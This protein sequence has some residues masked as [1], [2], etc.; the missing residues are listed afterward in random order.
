MSQRD[1]KIPWGLITP[2]TWQPT[3][4]RRGQKG[5]RMTYPQGIFCFFCLKTKPRQF[6]PNSTSSKNP[7]PNSS[8]SPKPKKKHL[9]FASLP[10]EL[11]HLAIASSWHCR[12]PHPSDSA[13]ATQWG[14]EKYVA[15][16]IFPNLAIGFLRYPVF[17]TQS[18]FFSWGSE[19]LIW[20][21]GRFLLASSPENCQAAAAAC[22]SQAKA[23]WPSASRLK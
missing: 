15:G 1:A 18:L 7:S 16:S 17:L 20:R 14:W 21:F 8:Q 23:L 2:Q 9:A 11:V 3:K 13:R 4:E 5:S 6:Y 22:A 12:P 10:A 19:L